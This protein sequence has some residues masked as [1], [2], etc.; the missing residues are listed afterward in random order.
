MHDP[1]LA[2]AGRTEEWLLTMYSVDTKTDAKVQQLIR[3]EFQGYTIIMI[4]HRLSSLVD[5]DRVAV[6]DGGR[7]VEF[8]SPVELLKE[9][10]GHFARLY[11]KS[12]KTS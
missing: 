11:G 12:V 9:G 6:L 3:T 10:S 2:E 5:F 1:K 8:G 7:L 4:A